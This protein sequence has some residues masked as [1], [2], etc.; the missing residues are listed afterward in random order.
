MTK[1]EDRY[2]EAMEKEVRWLR[3]FIKRLENSPTAHG[4]QWK[5]AMLQHYRKKLR[6]L[7]TERRKPR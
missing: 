7:R 4:K 3:K 5:F 6:E 1:A 2:D